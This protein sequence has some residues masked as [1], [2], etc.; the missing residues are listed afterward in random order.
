MFLIDPKHDGGSS[1][2]I[3]PV[4]MTYEVPCSSACSGY[5]EVL[6]DRALESEV[7]VYACGGSESYGLTACSRG[8]SAF[9]YVLIEYLEVYGLN[10]GGSLTYPGY[11]YPISD[12][13]KL[14]FEEEGGVACG[15]G[16][17]SVGTCG[18]T[19]GGYGGEDVIGGGA[20]GGVVFF[21]EEEEVIGYLGEGGVEEG[22]FVGSTTSK[23]DE[24]VEGVVGEV[25]RLCIE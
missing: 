7:G 1:E 22:E 11:G 12:M 19:I 9:L 14:L 4:L 10:R 8:C 5:G 23:E 20:Y 24:V 15:I 21:I 25:A 13:I 6:G 16:R 3:Y 2:R 17:S 18:R